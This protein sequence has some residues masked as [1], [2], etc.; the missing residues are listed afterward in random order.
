M[1]VD[2]LD[3]SPRFAYT[4]SMRKILFTFLLLP[5]F[6]LAWEAAPLHLEEISDT[7]YA[8]FS[9]AGE[10]LPLDD[11]VLLEGEENVGSEENEESSRE[12]APH[13]LALALALAAIH[14]T[15]GVKHRL[16]IFRSL[17]HASSSHLQFLHLRA[18]PV[19]I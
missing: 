15:H 7:G 12:S 4:A 5:A 18:P 8:Y 2:S 13:N 1:S 11:L 9:R 14:H 17:G 3:F 6:L 19:L 10:N 16:K